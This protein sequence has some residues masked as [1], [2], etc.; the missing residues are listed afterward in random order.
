VFIANNVVG[1]E[2]RFGVINIRGEDDTEILDNMTNQEKEEILEIKNQPNLYEKLSKSICPMVFGNDEIKKG[3]M[4]MLF[5]GIHK[6]TSEG[7]KLR[8]DINICV[9][10][11]PS[12]AKS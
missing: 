10:G 1:T 8:G 9:V 3:V 2:N 11:D 7:I 6:K 4:L 5:G 12:T